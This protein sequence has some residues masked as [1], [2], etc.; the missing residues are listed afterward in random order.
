MND[1]LDSLKC[2][3]AILALL[4]VVSALVFIPIL[5][6]V[7]YTPLWAVAE[8]VTAPVGLALLMWGAIKL[9]EW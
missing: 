8:I 4:A 6:A 5:L 9:D 1:F 3:Y 7:E 2:T